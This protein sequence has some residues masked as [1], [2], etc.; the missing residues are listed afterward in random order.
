MVEKGADVNDSDKP[1]LLGAPDPVI[2]SAVLGNKVKNVEMLITLGADIHKLD[3]QDEGT[4]LHSAASLGYVDIVK[5][6]LRH[7]CDK[8]VEDHYG[9]KAIDNARAN[10]KDEI[11]KLLSK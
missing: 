7:G 10:K 6:L 9:S 3:N 8:N 2:F 11:V 1:Q 5:V 4:L